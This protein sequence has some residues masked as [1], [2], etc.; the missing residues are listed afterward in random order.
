MQTIQIPFDGFY[1]SASDSLIEDVIN[2]AFDYEGTGCPEIPDEF[3]NQWNS[4]DVCIAYSKLYV[5]RFNMYL[6]DILGI[7]IE[8]EFDA[9]VSPKYYNFETDRIFCKIKDKDVSKLWSLTNKSDFALMVKERHSSRD[10]FIS[11]YANDA[12]VEPWSKPMKEWDSVQLQTMLMAC[13][14]SHGIGEISTWDIMEDCSGSG[15]LD[16]VVWNNCPKPCL[17][18]VNMYDESHRK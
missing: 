14:E 15:A 11:F 10:G 8:L 12:T 18:M 9:L 5:E 4:K 6:N 7:E 16:N 13:L 3:W 17:D 1:E 2:Q